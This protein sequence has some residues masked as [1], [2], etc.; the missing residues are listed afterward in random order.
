VNKKICVYKYD[1]LSLARLSLV[2]VVPFLTQYFGTRL[3]RPSLRSI[4]TVDNAR[5]FFGILVS[6]RT[7]CNC[8]LPQAF[9]RNGVSHIIKMVTKGKVAWINTSWIITRVKNV[10]FTWIN[11]IMNNVRRSMGEHGFIK[12]PKYTVRKSLFHFVCSPLPTVLSLVNF[13]EKPFFIFFIYHSSRHNAWQISGEGI[14]TYG[15]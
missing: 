12:K 15:E 10:F 11:A 6:S 14:F 5:V 13:S 3:T 9:F 7:V 4:S 1:F 2:P 8:E